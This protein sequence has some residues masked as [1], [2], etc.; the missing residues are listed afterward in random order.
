MIRSLFASACAVVVLFGL[1][2]C[3]G[4]GDASTD[5]GA[6]KPPE[7]E[8][9]PLVVYSGRGESLVGPLFEKLAADQILPVE[10]QVQYGD[11]AELATRLVTEGRES[12]ADVFFAQD[13][14]HL[15]ALAARGRLGPI[16]EDHFAGVDKRYQDPDGKWIGTSSRLRVLVHDTKR[17]PAS[18]MPKSLKDLA[19]KRWKGKLAWAPGNS[20]FISHVS[21]LRHTWGEEETRAWLEAVKAN[22]PTSYP[23]NSPMV[24][25][26]NT[27]EIQIGWT[28]HYYLHRT[29][30]EGRRA[31]NYS[32]KNSQDAGNLLMVSGVGVRQGTPN[33][34]M[35]NAFVGWL[36]SDEIQ[37][38]FA[39][40]C[41][42]Y[43]VRA[44]IDAHPDVPPL[45]TVSLAD[46][47][48]RF[49]ADLSGTRAML[50]EVG[51]Q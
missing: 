2:A 10:V 23:K 20:S 8:L 41:F 50:Q 14:G 42:E 47:D 32:F 51:L 48:Q 15:S 11:T 3:K 28:N 26:A 27:G 19:D 6:E 38:W 39:T 4:G 46:V 37:Q 17:L 44:G 24:A 1:A 7:P 9:Q 33:A 25:A 12:P 22:E 36:L 35:A 18:K 16:N 13:S 30:A 29:E 49:L 45:S 40:E 21:F 31:A 34:K 43:P 5:D